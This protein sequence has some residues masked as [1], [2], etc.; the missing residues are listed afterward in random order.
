[1]KHTAF[2]AFILCITACL[3]SSKDKPT[4]LYRQRIANSKY[5]IYEFTYPASFV[6]S[7]DFSGLAV[8]D[9]NEV[10]SKDKILPLPSYYFEN[11]PTSK[12]LKMIDIT[13]GPNPSTAADTFLA[14]AKKYRIN[15]NGFNIDVTEYKQTYGSAT[16]STGLMEYSFELFKETTDSLIFYKVKKRFGGKDFPTTVSFLKGNIKIIES[17]GKQIDYIEINRAIITRGPIYKPTKP[18]ELV[19]NQPITGFATYYFY[20]TKNLSST[21]FTDFGIFKQI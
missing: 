10:F 3:N 6:T 4:S 19:V 17:A 15:N 13:D 16:S 5:V 18:F 12:Q 21:R 1:M 14:P 9:S 7:S 2:L 20:P 11:K 8:L